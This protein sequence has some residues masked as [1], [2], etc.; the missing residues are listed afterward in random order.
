M[1]VGGHVR[2]R[3]IYVPHVKASSS[4]GEAE[5]PMHNY[6]DEGLKQH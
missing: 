1:C 5:D 4:L 2:S 6:F 3:T